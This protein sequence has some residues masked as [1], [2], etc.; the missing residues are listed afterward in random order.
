MDLVAQSVRASDCGSEGR[1][2]DPHPSP[3]LKWDVVS[4][5]HPIFYFS[6]SKHKNQSCIKTLKLETSVF[7]IIFTK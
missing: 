4:T 5:R 6:M 2:F 1:G 3:T 7:F